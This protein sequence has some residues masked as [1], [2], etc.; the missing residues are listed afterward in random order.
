M[1]PD[2][3][4]MRGRA[5]LVPQENTA[6]KLPYWNAKLVPQESTRM[7]ARGKSMP[8]LAK[9]ASRD[10]ILPFKDTLKDATCASPPRQLGQALA[11]VVT[12]ECTERRPN[13]AQTRRIS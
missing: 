2:S 9:L 12:Q 8:Q 7:Q 1:S 10:N 13:I 3:T 5:K 4:L 11:T 6:M